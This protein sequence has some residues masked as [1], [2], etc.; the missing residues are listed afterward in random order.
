LLDDLI[1]GRRFG[2]DL[3]R[4]LGIAGRP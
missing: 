2:G 1:A 3:E 4:E